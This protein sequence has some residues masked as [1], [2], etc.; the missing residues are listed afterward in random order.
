M[1]KSTPEIFDAIAQDKSKALGDWPDEAKV[2]IFDLSIRVGLGI[3]R[4]GFGL[5]R[6]VIASAE[7]KQKRWVLPISFDGSYE[8]L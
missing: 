1:V 7:E 2:V 4:Y 6:G 3:K 8:K 5:D